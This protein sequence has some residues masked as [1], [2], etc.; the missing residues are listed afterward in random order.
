MSN[1][2]DMMSTPETP[3]TSAWWV[4]E[5]SAKRSPSSP[6]TSQT[7]QSG[8]SRSSCWEKT[9]PARSI[10]WL[11]GA[12]G[13]ERGGA[14]VVAQVQVRIVDPAAGG[15]GRAARR[16]AAGG[17]AARAG[18]GARRPRAARRR[19][20]A[21][22]RRSSPTAT[23]MCEDGV[24]QVQERCVES[25]QPVVRHA[26]LQASARGLER[27]AQLIGG[28]RPPRAPRRGPRRARRAGAPG[29][30]GR[31]GAAARPR[32]STRRPARSPAAAIERARVTVEKSS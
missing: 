18:A 16:P 17:S 4:F 2:T 14:H 25:S 7:S 3:S 22:P 27:K 10:S 19:G 30:A 32:P 11:L 24:L 6:S 20:E 23:C 13:G 31:A 26:A 21:D 28:S 5:S 8:L 12:G 1:R 15:P 29:A 9:R